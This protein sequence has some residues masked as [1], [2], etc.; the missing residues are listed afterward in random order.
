MT[1]IGYHASHEQVH[2]RAL[3]DHVRDAE[4]AGF[5][6]AMC[7][8]H[9]AP[10]GR[11]QGHSGY[12]WSWLGAALAT[13][14]LPFGIVTAPGQRYHPA[15]A[16]QKIAT[17][18]AMFPGRFWAALG[19]GEALNEH[20]TGDPWPPKP[21]RNERLL[22]CVAVMRALLDGDEVCHEGLVT[23]DRARLWTLPTE[24]PALLAAA[25]SPE[26]AGWA[27]GWADGLITVNGEPDRLR[28][29]VDAY[30]S[31]GGRGPVVLQVHLAYA[32]TDDEA[33]RL[34]HDQ[35]RTNVFDNS[36]C[37]DL[38]LVEQFEAIAQHVRPD[39]VRSSV[40]VSS[41][42]GQHAQWIHDH[43]A[44]G[45]DQIYLHHVGQEQR[46][47]IDVFGTKVLPQ[48]QDGAR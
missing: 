36:V 28:G 13:T 43:L 14:S 37:W 39:D 29:V 27:A 12:A 38:E 25:V 40:L 32:A 47:F 26:T 17:L 30:R 41:D 20:I 3:L 4:R 21:V 8:D 7:S 16:A 42:A 10:W 23:V 44:L 35:W 6:A 11:Q 31:A 19:S 33:L 9:F 15:I 2:P 5:S 46:E 45:F 1:V 34:A 48:L 24:T 22:E 18:A